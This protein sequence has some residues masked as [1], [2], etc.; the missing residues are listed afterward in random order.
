MQEDRDGMR[1]N[2]DLDV[3]TSKDLRTRRGNQQG[4][5]AKQTGDVV[6]LYRHADRGKR[7]PEK[8]VDE[9]EYVVAWRTS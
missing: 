9:T 1:P 5:R 3:T 7:Q 6:M 4:R 2:E 8:D